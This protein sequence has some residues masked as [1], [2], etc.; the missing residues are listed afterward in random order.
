MVGWIMELSTKHR[1]VPG[2]YISRERVNLIWHGLP[3]V[4]V[5]FCDKIL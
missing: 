4:V 2:G 5:F 3:K 1:T